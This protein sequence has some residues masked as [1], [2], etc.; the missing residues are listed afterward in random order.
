LHSFP[1]LKVQAI[2]DTGDQT[3]K[4]PSH[5][6]VYNKLLQPT[7]GHDKTTQSVSNH[8]PP[9]LYRQLPQSGKLPVLNLLKR[10]K[11]SIFAPQERLFAPIHVKFGTTEGQ[12]GPLGL[13]KFHANQCTGVGTRTCPQKLKISTFG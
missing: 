11:I 10:P 4:T 2:G 1:S 13:A 5:W 3:E 12:V 9:S 7:T 6:M 8:I